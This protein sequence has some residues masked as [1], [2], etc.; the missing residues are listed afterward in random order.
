MLVPLFR[1]CVELLVI[2]VDTAP[3][4]STYVI[5]SKQV[6]LIDVAKSVDKID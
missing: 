3:K 1:V 6:F 2:F 5:N 4:L